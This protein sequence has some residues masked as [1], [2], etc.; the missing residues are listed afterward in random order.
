MRRADPMRVKLRPAGG[1]GYRQ[2]PISAGRKPIGA[3]PLANGRARAGFTKKNFSPPMPD[4]G[5]SSEIGVPRMLT[6]VTIGLG[7]L[8]AAPRF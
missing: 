3:R 1:R 6:S 2:A 5:S 7:K 8:P 4:L